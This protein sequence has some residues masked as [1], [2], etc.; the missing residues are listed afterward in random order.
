MRCGGDCRCSLDPELLWLWHWLVAT[1]L[2]GPLTWETPYAMG[3]AL[4]RENKK[5]MTTKNFI[6]RVAPSIIFFLF[7]FRAAP[8]AH[9]VPRLGAKLEL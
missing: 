9:E 4:K 2:I 8:L 1:A 3:V 5:T 7:L 6:S